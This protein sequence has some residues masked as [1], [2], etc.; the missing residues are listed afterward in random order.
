MKTKSQIIGIAVL[1]LVAA[2]MPA[3][4]GAEPEAQRY[5][6]YGDEMGGGGSYLG[7]DTRDI[8]TDRMP[9][10]HVKD[11]N[12]V[13]VTM[14]DQ[15]APAGKAGLKEHDVILSINDQKIESV[16]QLRRVVHEIPPGR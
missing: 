13:E 8:T 9:D 5:V 2:G 10:L 14:V 6:F 1:F 16:E 4:V 7:V 3:Q 11:E 15:D 12:G